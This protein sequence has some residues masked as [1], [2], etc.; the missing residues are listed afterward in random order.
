[1]KLIRES[2]E[3]HF[4]TTLEKLKAD[5]KGWLILHFALSKALKH[6][7]LIKDPKNIQN[8]ISKAR[9]KSGA[10]IEEL[11]K[12][13]GEIESGFVYLFSDND[14]IVVV[15]AA[16]EE[17]KKLVHK[18]YEEMAQKIPPELSST[19]VV[20]SDLSKYQKIADGKLLTA[21]RFEAYYAMSDSNKVSSIPVR[22]HR[23]HDPKVL[24]IEDD[25]FT[26]AYTSN[27]LSKDY[28]LVVARTGEEGVSAYIEHAPDIVFLDIHLPGMNGHETLEAIRAV[29][30]KS[31]VVMLSVD[32]EK[33]S[34]RRATQSGAKSFLKKP[35]SKERLINTVK[36]SLRTGP[37]DGGES[38]H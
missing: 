25:R 18:V 8:V 21:S 26:A 19:G 33:E 9:A 16:N 1:M 36:T 34:I 2:A 10:F 30:S 5:P 29:D 27:I 32:T 28:D 38:V 3:H 12:K 15:R 22:R 13:T 14:V 6:A 23:R 35:F 31:F 24:I 7:A 4:L 20:I 11:M 17:Q 37:P